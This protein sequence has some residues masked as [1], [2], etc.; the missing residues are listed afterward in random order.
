[1]VKLAL[2]TLPLCYF[3]IAGDIETNPGPKQCKFPCGVCSAP[4]KI[5]QSGVQCDVCGFWLHSRCIGLSNEPLMTPG[6]VENAFCL[7]IISQILIQFLTPLVQTLALIFR[8]LYKLQLINLHFC[9]FLQFFTLIAG[10]C[11]LRLIILETIN[12]CS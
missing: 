9:I 8:T 4:V 10:A 11:L 12:I 6:V 1:M 7:S 5:N 3:L 2:A